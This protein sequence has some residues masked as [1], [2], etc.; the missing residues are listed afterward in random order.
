MNQVVLAPL[1]HYF[2]LSS[3]WQKLN[4]F[5]YICELLI[6]SNVTKLPI[7]SLD[8]LHLFQHLVH[9]AN[10]QPKLGGWVFSFSCLNLLQKRCKVRFWHTVM[11]LAVL[12]PE[13]SYVPVRDLVQPSVSDRVLPLQQHVSFIVQGEHTSEKLVVRSVSSTA[14]IPQHRRP[15]DVLSAVVTSRVWQNCEDFLLFPVSVGQY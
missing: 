1:L 4:V 2:Q 10:L 8:K 12:E 9:S 14:Q 11:I 7:F 6:S 5:K 15:R 13:T 3:Y